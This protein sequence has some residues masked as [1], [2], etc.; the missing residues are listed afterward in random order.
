MAGEQPST[1]S[2]G[3]GGGSEGSDGGGGGEA[4]QPRM[5]QPHRCNARVEDFVQAIVTWDWS[6]KIQP[7]WRLLR[8][9]LKSEPGQEPT[10]PYLIIKDPQAYLDP[11]R[12]QGSHPG[13]VQRVGRAEPQHRPRPGTCTQSSSAMKYAATLAVLAAL[14]VS[15]AVAATPPSY[16]ASV[17]HQ[18]AGTQPYPRGCN[19]RAITIAVGQGSSAVTYDFTVDSG[20]GLLELSCASSTSNANCPKA[21]TNSYKLSSSKVLNTQ[22]TCTAAGSGCL[23]PGSQQCYYSQGL[24]GGTGFNGNKGVF[25]KDTI[26]VKNMLS[27]SL[28]FPAAFACAEATWK[29]SETDTSCIQGNQTC[30]STAAAASNILKGGCVGDNA[31]IEAGFT[32]SL[33]G[34]PSAAALP[35]QVFQS[36][37]IKNRTLG[38]CWQP[39]QKDSN[40]S[41][42]LASNSA[43]VFGPARPA[44]LKNAVLS[45]SPL[46]NATFGPTTGAAASTHTFRS[47]VAG[48]Y[49][50]GG[51]GV[52]PW[53][54]SYNGSVPSVLWDSG[55]YGSSEV[56]TPVFNA[57][58]N[59]YT[60]ARAKA[61]NEWSGIFTI[62]NCDAKKLCGSNTPPGAHAC[63]YIALPSNAT[64]VHRVAA[65]NALLSMYPPSI[66]I[67]LEGGAI[68][69]LPAAFAVNDCQGSGYTSQAGVA[70]CSYVQA[71]PAGTG[72]GAGYFWVAGPWFTSRFVQFD[73]SPS[74][75]EFPTATAGVIR[76]SNTIAS[77]A[78]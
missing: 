25:A 71:P 63:Q 3:G 28:S 26:T 60:A 41:A 4:P 75:P 24:T 23:L 47:N 49:I 46:I 22:A 69:P 8:K 14:A 2:R 34:R 70:V 6:G 5:P 7:T 21:L 78:F 9:C 50:P 74:P 31:G 40:C 56:P 76:F 51:N 19:N 18:K 44:A 52:Q 20:S 62:S 15:T 67:Q 59:Y 36:G 37:L 38:F 13:P 16:V 43:V 33:G 66:D 45:V 77:C 48:V 29:C 35:E 58:L 17:A 57:F 68:A 54:T 10:D 42:A 72:G 61:V 39:P 27:G 30:P 65:R 53:K 12:F 1:S 32:F 55:A 73:L 64:A 11:K